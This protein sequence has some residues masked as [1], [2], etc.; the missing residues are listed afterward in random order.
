MQ[1]N[2]YLFYRKTWSMHCSSNASA[3]SIL[4]C[5]LHFKHY[6]TEII[7]ESLFKAKVNQGRQLNG[8]KFKTLKQYYLS[9]LCFFPG[10]K[11]GK[12]T[13][14]IAF[15]N[16]YD[17]L[18]MRVVK[19]SYRRRDCI[20]RNQWVFFMLSLNKF[21]SKRNWNVE[22]EITRRSSLALGSH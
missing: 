21:S 19:V 13:A 1:C 17:F 22:Y 2:S 5:Q 16:S 12:F 11:S 6:L 3:S 4:L 9:L 10:K 8:Q 15:I 18:K 7:L 14:L 20:V